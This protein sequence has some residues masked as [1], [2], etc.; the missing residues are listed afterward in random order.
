MN[1][2]TRR[3]TDACDRSAA[4]AVAFMKRLPL[5]SGLAD[6]DLE[7]L[8]EHARPLV[9]P[10]GTVIMREGTAGDGLYVLVRG[11]IEITRSEA[12]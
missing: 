10:A 9:V 4:E 12:G 8:L 3:L 5:L 1:A 11:R 6:A 2:R 7:R